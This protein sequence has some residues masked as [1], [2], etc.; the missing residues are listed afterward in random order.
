MDTSGVAF[1]NEKYLE[2]QSKAILK[3]IERFDNKLYLEFGGKLVFDHHA[4]RVLPGF[5][6]NVKMRL[7]NRLAD[8]AEII[9][10]IYAG[11]IESKKIRADFGI[12]YDADTFKL[13]DDLREWGLVVRAVVITRFE[14]QPAAETFRTKLERRG[15]R[16]YTH[17]PIEGYARDISRTVSHEGYG[18]NPYIETER[19]LVVVNAPGPNSGKMATCLSQVYHEHRRGVDAGYAKFETFPIWNLPLKHPVNSAYEAATAELRD[20]NLIDPFHLEAHKETAVN[21]NRDVEAFPLLK[22][23]LERIIGADSVY[24]SPT[25]M[26]VNRA[27]YAIV[28]DAA[29]REAAKQEIIRRYFRYSCEYASGLADIETVQ[30]VEALMEENSVRPENRPTVIPAREAAA[31]AEQSA[32]KGHEGA[33]VG[34]SLQLPNGSIATGRNSPLM[35]AASSL[36]IN[37]IKQL[38]GIPRQLELLGDNIIGSVAKLKKEILARRSISLDVGEVLVALSIGGTTNPTA[39]LALEQLPKLRGCEAHMTHIPTPGDERGLRGLGVNLT[40]DP[41]FASDRLFVA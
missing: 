12:S 31:K 13:I 16:V 19:P 15:V 10:C 6:P 22:R 20:V 41:V 21:Y 18:S 7:L 40:S 1:D 38:A 14:A 30:R 39:R 3:R 28:D 33:F 36:V 11:D 32:G 5:D 2:E 29:A 34:A 23:I 27:G 26:G 35:H 24:Q 4:S 25:D 37:S 8:K 17:R 9:I